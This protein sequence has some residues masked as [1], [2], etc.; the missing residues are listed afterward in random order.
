MKKWLRRFRGA[1]GM[2]VAWAAAWGGVGALLA[3]LGFLGLPFGAPPL[4]WFVV[5]CAFSFGV[6]G[7]MAGAFFS[8]VL[9]ILE[10][11]RRFDEMSLL[12]FA[13]GGAL[14]W[15]ILSTFFPDLLIFFL[16]LDGRISLD[17][18]GLFVVIPLLG[19]SSAAGSLALARRADDR[20]LLEHGADVA[21][22]GLTEEEKSQRPSAREGEGLPRPS[23]F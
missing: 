21:D 11:R 20:E 1:L 6:A 23:N 7:F 18:L 5:L 8:T 2:G 14:G 9:W 4:G 22:T 10:G 15:V 13:F 16:F 17:L 3:L 12:R 19:A